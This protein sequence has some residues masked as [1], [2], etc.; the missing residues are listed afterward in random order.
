MLD[1]IVLAAGAKKSRASVVGRVGACKVGHEV[2][3][4][5][6]WIFCFTRPSNT[7]QDQELGYPSRLTSLSP[8]KGD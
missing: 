6:D 1:S 7:C 4:P 5:A 2:K 3:P 8:D